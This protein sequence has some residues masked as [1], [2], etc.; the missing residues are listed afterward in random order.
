MFSS[1]FVDTLAGY[2]HFAISL[3]L[4]SHIRAILL[5]VFL[6]FRPTLRECV[7]LYTRSTH[8]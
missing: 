2:H 1:S 3:S 6:Q 8:S 5:I 7:Y 4:F